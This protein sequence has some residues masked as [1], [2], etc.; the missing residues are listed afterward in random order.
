MGGWSSPFEERTL[1]ATG[2]PADR[3][4]ENA[5]N[6]DQAA[7]SLM[8]E[9]SS[10]VL[11]VLSSDGIL[12]SQSP[13]IRNVTGYEP[14]ERLGK[15]IFELV[16]PDDQPGAASAFTSLLEKQNATMSL[17]LRIRHKD[18]SWRLV[19][20]KGKNLLDD[21]TVAGIV[22]NFHEISPPAHETDSTRSD[23]DHIRPF[24]QTFSWM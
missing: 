16:H 22:A 1:A 17:E 10:D 18:G 6:A 14:E 13:S 19:E 7:F 20:A 4:A 15:S 5:S 23:D 11:M 8:A 21:P 9:T 2:I 24:I 3:E 12:R